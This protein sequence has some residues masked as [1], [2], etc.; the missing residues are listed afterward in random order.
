MLL[1]MCLCFAFNIDWNIAG[2]GDCAR[3]IVLRVAKLNKYTLI[4]TLNYLILRLPT[5][6]LI[7]DRTRDFPLN[8]TRC[9]NTSVLVASCA[10]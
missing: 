1:K 3:Q 8:L 6:G 10:E 7:S 2:G 9:D 4:L 5:L